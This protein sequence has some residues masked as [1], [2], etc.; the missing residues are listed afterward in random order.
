MFIPPFRVV[1]PWVPAA[2]VQVL[3]ATTG[4]VHISPPVHVV[5]PLTVRL[6]DPARTPLL[7]F[8][9]VAETG[10]PVE[11]TIVPELIVNA[12]KLLTSP[13][14]LK[15]VFPPRLAVPPVTP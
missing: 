6:S 5:S 4:V 9:V 12:P 15:F 10:F 14:P 2:A 3:L 11:N 7:S 1:I 13:G 8:K